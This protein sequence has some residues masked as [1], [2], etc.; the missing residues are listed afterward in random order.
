MI[1]TSSWPY[2]SGLT[3]TTP[4]ISRVISP[5][6]SSYSVPW[7]GYLSS[8]LGPGGVVV[9]FGRSVCFCLAQ[10]QESGSMVNIGLDTSRDEVSKIGA[11]RALQFVCALPR[12]S[13]EMENTRLLLS[14]LGGP[15]ASDLIWWLVARVV[16][17]TNRSVLR[18]KPYLTRKFLTGHLRRL[19]LRRRQANK[20]GPCS[21]V[22]WRG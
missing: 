9:P 15:G 3:Y 14:L 16:G 7:K 22:H 17:H 10:R 11:S 5:V 13:M 19:A 2:I 21:S 6:A 12:V 1:T 18:C 20:K 8:L 4:V